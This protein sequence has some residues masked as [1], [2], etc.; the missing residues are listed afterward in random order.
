MAAPKKTRQVPYSKILLAS[1]RLV[2]RPYKVS[3][4]KGCKASHDGRIIPVNKYDEPVPTP[5]SNGLMEFKERIKRQR[6]N[7][8]DGRHFIFGVF[9]K[10]SGAYLGQI[11]IFTISRELRWGNLGYHIQNQYFGKGYASEASKLALAV[12]FKQLGFHRI[13]AAME[14]DNKVS[15]KVAL[16]A[17]LI[18]E[19]VR[20]KFFPDDG[21]VDMKVFA[22]NAI[23]HR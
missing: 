2:L 23:D 7:G 18:F 20:K 5:S 19:G 14:L 21:G 3:D 16:R 13:E 22:T 8:K 12:A 15:Q 4:F 11:D 6:I 10:R 1:K 17:G 9:D